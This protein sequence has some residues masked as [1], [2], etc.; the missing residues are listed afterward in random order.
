[1]KNLDDGVTAPS[2]R[3]FVYK[4][5]ENLIREKEKKNAGPIPEITKSIFGPKQFIDFK[6]DPIVSIIHYLRIHVL[7]SV[8]SLKND[9]HRAF[10][11]FDISTVS[12]LNLR[13]L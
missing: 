1:M 8:D 6:F 4:R 10:C 7:L 2:T 11:S 5:E 9:K 3:V 13:S 12:F